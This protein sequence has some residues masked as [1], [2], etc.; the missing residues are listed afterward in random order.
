[1]SIKEIQRDGIKGYLIVGRFKSRTDQS[2]NPKQKRVFN[3]TLNDAKKIERELIQE[4]KKAAIHKD[5]VGLTLKS[6]VQQWHQRELLTIKTDTPTLKE[7]LRTIEIY[8]NSIINQPV[9]R[10]TEG[11]LE[12]IYAEMK[13]LD[14][15]HSRMRTL[16]SGLNSVYNWG[17]RERIIQRHIVCP[18]KFAK[19]P[20]SKPKKEQ[21]MLNRQ[22]ITKFI[23]M[24]R[25]SEHSYYD[26]WILAFLTGM[27]S[28]EL[29]ALK[30]ENV[31][32]E[33]NIINICSS[34]SSKL[35]IDKTTKNEKLRNFPI[36]SE[37]KSHLLQLK[38]R[39]QNSEYVLPRIT[40]WRR[41]EAAK[42][43]RGFCKAIGIREINFHAI[44]ACWAIQSLEARIEVP[45]VMRLGGWQGFKSFQH[46]IRLSG[47]EIEGVTD[48][49]SL[50]PPVINETKVLKFN[51]SID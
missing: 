4:A 29:H 28:G 8:A 21:P 31:D 23:Q 24:A 36:N 14:K 40:S 7:Y 1:M 13:S 43:T 6:L 41:G 3:I 50:I 27:R 39:T 51:K 45:K 34:Y 10:L 46:Y 30:W 44:R 49:F 37:L 17:Y 22:E 18:A 47:V 42:V 11:H 15:S 48:N 2:S 12:D 5:E 38:I 32:L 9:S 20:K 25:E 26:L 19:I 16:R 33:N 35:N